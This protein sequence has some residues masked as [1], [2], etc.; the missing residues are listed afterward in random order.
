MIAVTTGTLD[1]N[2]RAADL[3]VFAQTGSAEEALLRGIPTW[4]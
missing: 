2:L 4:Q 1:E 3:V